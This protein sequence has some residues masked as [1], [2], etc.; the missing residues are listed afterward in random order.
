[1]IRIVY[2]HGLPDVSQAQQQRWLESLPDA[3]QARLLRLRVPVKRL[4]SLI[5]T[6]L[7]K[8]L[9]GFY[10]RPEFSLQRLENTEYGKP[11][12]PD[13]PDF[14]V[15]HAGEL[16]ACAMADEGQIGLD[17]ERI[18]PIRTA[19]FDSIF[20]T[21]ELDWIGEQ[22]ARFFELW[23]KKE[24]VAKVSGHHGV[25]HLRAI[26]LDGNRACLEGSALHLN[27]VSL[28]ADYCA[29]VASTQAD[30]DIVIH[31]AGLVDGE[32]QIL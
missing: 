24:A 5:G 28:H 21:T 7:V 11:H 25:A 27:P 17:V 2:L 3:W 10:D 20:S 30:T 6:Q 26:Q 31:Q 29:C 1:M 14:S 23:T 22:A 9:A 12:S 32:W 19:H 4:Q 15:S 8:Q 16:V 13:L 18:R